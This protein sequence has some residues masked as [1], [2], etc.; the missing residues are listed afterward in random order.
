MKRAIYFADRHLV[1]DEEP[2][3]SWELFLKFVKDFKPD[4][5]VDGGDHL[6]LPYIS[7]FNKEKLLLLEGKRLKED[8]DAL[9]DEL[10]ILRQSCDRMLFLEGNHEERLKRAIEKQPLLQGMAELESNIDFKGL[11]IEYYPLLKQPVKIG[12]L[13]FLHGSYTGLHHAK[14]H[15]LKFM[16][17]LCYGHVHEFQSYYQGI[18]LRNDE[19]GA[20]SIG[21]LS[22]KNPDYLKGKPAHWQNGFAVIY[23]TDK[24]YYNLYPIIMTKR[25]FIFEGKEYAV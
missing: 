5:L 7:S 20:N 12:K 23:F 22:S 18:P 19:M 2:H 21:I 17:N 11:D 1:H 3:W 16:G 6:D 14:K 13:H 4:I 8:F 10:A 15:L 24:G 25:K 9:S